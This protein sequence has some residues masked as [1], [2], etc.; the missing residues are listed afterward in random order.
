MIDCVNGLL[1]DNEYPLTRLPANLCSGAGSLFQ[2][3][4]D[5]A[6]RRRTLPSGT[7]RDSN[8][9]QQDER[10]D[11]YGWFRTKIRS[12]F[13]LTRARRKA[14]RLILSTVR[15]ALS[16]LIRTLS[17]DYVVFSRLVRPHRSSSPKS[18]R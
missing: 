16:L 2:E 5:P 6:R 15:A 10:T 4:V 14:A 13:D 7:R 3:H 18:Q 11:A 1:R 12:D 8:R 9:G 17:S